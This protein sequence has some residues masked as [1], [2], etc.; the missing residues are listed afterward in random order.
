ML[1]LSHFVVGFIMAFLGLTAPGLLTLTA[2]KTAVERGPKE[3]IKFAAGVIFP[4]IVQAHMA[5]LGAEYLLEHPE[6]LMKFSKAAVVLFLILSFL[7]YKQARKKR[8]Q[9]TAV[10]KFNIRNS[11]L[12][13]VFISLI[14]PMAI[15][16]Y[17]T[18]SSLLRYYGIIQFE[19]PY[20]SIFVA[21]ALLG[22]FSI[23]SIYS[24]YARRLIGK[25]AFLSRNFNYIV[26]FIFLFL[27]VAGIVGNIVK[28]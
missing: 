23:L 12:Y 4:V 7:I 26:S 21:G 15:P 1:Y 18:Y 28:S 14:N 3:G 5:I 11:F 27:A 10:G 6:I 22:A 16:F 25:F 24:V 13:G 20:V 2:L 9:E 19:Q 8:Y 17:F